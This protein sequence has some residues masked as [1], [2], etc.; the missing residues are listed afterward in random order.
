[1]IWLL[2]SPVDGFIII[3]LVLLDITTW[4]FELVPNTICD[5]LFFDEFGLAPVKYKCPE[6]EV[7]PL[8]PRVDDKVVAPVTP[9]VPPTE[10]LLLALI[11]V[12]SV[13]A[14]L[15]FALPSNDCPHNVRGVFSFAALLATPLVK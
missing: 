14:P 7:A 1:M 15:T 11:V 3:A 4:L 2:E 6:R 13:I 8:T 9:N 10:T 5:V 12:A